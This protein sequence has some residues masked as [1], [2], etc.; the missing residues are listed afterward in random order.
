[1]T[2]ERRELALHG[3]TV[4]YFTAGQG[5]VVVL[6]HGIASSAETWSK[7]IPRLADRYTV[8]AP[9]LLGHG[10]SAKPMGDYSLGAFAS[11]VRDLLAALG[12]DRATVVGHSLGGGVAMQYAYQ[13]PARCE[14]LVLVSSGGLGRELSILLRAASLPGSELVLPV[15]TS[16]PVRNGVDRVADR[17]RR[18]GIRPAASM[19]ETWLS[20]TS[21]AQDDA[22]RAFLRTLR[23]IVDVGGQR[24]SAT[25]R[26]YLARE[27]P[28]LIAWGGR[29][30]IIPLRHATDAH[31]AM[32][33]SELKVFADAGHFPHGD[34]PAV[35]AE[36]LERF[37]ET[38]EPAAIDERDLRSMLDTEP[39][40]AGR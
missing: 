36:T 5:P 33:G 6:L 15:L 27:I 18:V 34:E 1:M 10:K 19:R 8:I 23:T 26:L 12:H 2:F 4:S 11:G 40:S 3:H 17:L 37:I 30:R 32:P 14:R 13:F 24:V 16:E 21:L 22:R 20:I 38:T 29:D 9:D 7:L 35:F 31:A 25:D 39:V 28:T